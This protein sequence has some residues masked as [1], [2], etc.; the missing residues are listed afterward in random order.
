MF[1]NLFV[2]VILFG[3]AVRAV[4]AHA[5]AV[6]IAVAFHMH[7]GSA[8]GNF[9]KFAAADARGGAERSAQYRFTAAGSFKR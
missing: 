1:Q 6:A 2:I 5:N 8:D 4:L 3:H 9:S 7:F